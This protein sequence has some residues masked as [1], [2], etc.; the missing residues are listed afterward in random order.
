MPPS[1]AMQAA[2]SDALLDA[3]AT[4]DAEALNLAEWAFEM[5]MHEEDLRFRR[6]E[7]GAHT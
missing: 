7:R 4:G 2:C 3:A 1:L 6:L 5:E